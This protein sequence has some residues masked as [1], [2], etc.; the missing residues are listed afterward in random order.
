MKPER[1]NVYD[2]LTIAAIL[3]GIALPAY[4]VL[5]FVLKFW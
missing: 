3:L 5:H 4:I 2:W 1:L